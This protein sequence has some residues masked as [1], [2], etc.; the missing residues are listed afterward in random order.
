MA[1]CFRYTLNAAMCNCEYFVLIPFS[2]TVRYAEYCHCVDNVRCP[3][4]VTCTASPK[5]PTF[6]HYITLQYISSPACASVRLS[7]CPSHAGIVSKQLKTGSQSL[8]PPRHTVLTPLEVSPPPVT[9]SPELPTAMQYMLCHL[10]TGF[11]SL[12]LDCVFSIIFVLELRAEGQTDR[13][14]Q[15]V[16]CLPRGGDITITTRR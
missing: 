12:L 11:T 15:F 5:S 8:L 1:N 13:Q 16:V 4:S 7:V 10:T 6:L 3:R 14:M 9:P 2:F